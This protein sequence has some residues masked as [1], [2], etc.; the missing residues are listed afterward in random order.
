MAFKQDPM[1]LRL[2]IG[3]RGSEFALSEEDYFTLFEFEPF[4]VY[5][6]PQA[7]EAFKH[8]CDQVHAKY[9][10]MDVFKRVYRRYEKMM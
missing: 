4:D 1:Q 9:P 10:T 8:S 7:Y 3:I 6:L 2:A 5:E